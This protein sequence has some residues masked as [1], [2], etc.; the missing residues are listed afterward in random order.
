MGFTF[1]TT[2][3]KRRFTVE[4]ENDSFRQ[5]GLTPSSTL[6]VIPAASSSNAAGS[7]DIFTMIMSLLMIPINLVSWIFGLFTGAA[8]QQSID[9][10]APSSSKGPST[11][12]AARRRNMAHLSDLDDD[13]RK[14]KSQ[15]NGNSTEQDS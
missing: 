6:T 14:N 9:Q 13:D 3:P 10:S 8:Q 11:N 7:N 5:L 15:Y 4:E 12:D 1:G 2:F